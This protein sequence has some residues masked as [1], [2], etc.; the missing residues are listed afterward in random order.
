LT[1]LAGVAVLVA[2]PTSSAQDS[3]VFIDPD[4]PSGREYSIPL[5]EARREAG[6]PAPGK[7]A[8]GERTAPLFGEGVEAET[9]PAAADETAPTRAGESREPRGSEATDTRRGDE[10]E[11]SP[12][13]AASSGAAERSG[14][15]GD[16]SQDVLIV[17]TIGL[18]T[19]AIGA[20]VGVMARRRL[21]SS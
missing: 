13:T 20:A 12:A 18:G 6:G 14:G 1:L 9:R 3:G 5:E 7:V 8:L 17:G 11:A 21:T 4:S 16:G 2:A 10:R 15:D 19:L